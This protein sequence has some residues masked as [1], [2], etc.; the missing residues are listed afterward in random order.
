MRIR[1][2]LPLLFLAAV[3]V[4]S[5]PERVSAQRG[6]CSNCTRCAFGKGTMCQL[7]FPGEIDFGFTNCKQQEFCTC[8]PGQLG[9]CFPAQE[10]AAADLEELLA[11]TVAAI[12]AGEAIPADG[13]FFYLRRGAEFVIRPRSDA[14]EVG[15]VAVADVEPAPT[16]ARG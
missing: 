15:R 10:L 14:A 7:L 16:P 13:P 2:L 3:I 9:D 8:Y 4:A 11:G 12:Q 5:L 6:G 1:K